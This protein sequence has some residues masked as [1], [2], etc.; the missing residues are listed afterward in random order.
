[1]GFKD[2]EPSAFMFVEAIKL[3]LMVLDLVQLWDGPVPGYRLIM[4]MRGSTI[5]HVAKINF[6]TMKRGLDYQQVR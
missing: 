5:Q 3:G 6:T 2:P 1:M 4:D